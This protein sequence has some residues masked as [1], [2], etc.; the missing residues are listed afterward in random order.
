MLETRRRSINVSDNVQGVFPVCVCSRAIRS[1]VVAPSVFTDEVASMC[2]PIH[3]I[4]CRSTQVPLVCVNDNYPPE[5]RN[6]DGS[7]NFP[8][9]LPERSDY[10]LQ[11]RPPIEAGDRSPQVQRK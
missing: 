11:V 1:V 4:C 2:F 10:I 9:F 8:D 7:V 5:L 6:D 3:A